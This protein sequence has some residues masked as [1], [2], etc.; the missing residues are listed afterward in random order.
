MEALRSYSV[1]EQKLVY[2]AYFVFALMWTIG[3][4]VA[5]DKITN[6]RRAFN[7]WIKA[8]SKVKFPDTGDAF[9]YRF[10]AVAKEWVHWDQF[11]VA[12]EPITERMYQNIVV[13]TVELERM[14]YVLDL[15]VN[16]G[17]PVLYVGT[18]G[19]SK[20]TIVK[21]YL[22]EVAV[23]RDDM[24]SASINHNNYTSS[25]ALQA[26]MTG[27]LDKR[28]GRTYGPPGNRKCIFFIDDLNMPALDTYDTQSAIML[29]NQIMSYSSVFDRSRLEERK[30]LTDI[31]FTACMNPKSGSFMINTRLQRHFTC[32]TTFAPTA[33]VI[34]GI[35]AKILGK[36]LESFVGQVQKLMEPIVNV[37]IDTLMAILNTSCFLPSA[38][39]FFYQ[40]N[41]KD[42]SN[43]FQ[44]LLNTNPAQFREG[45]TK[46]ARVWVHEAK[47]V[48]A[49]RLINAS[50]DAEL[51][52]ILE[53][54]C[55]KHLQGI[56]KDELFAEPLIF[57]SFCSML[58]GNDK[59]YLPIKE[60]S[61]LKDVVEAKLKE[62]NESYAAM[63]L[64]LFD[65]ALCHVCR[66]C[67]ITD[68]PCGNALLVGLV[69]VESRV[70]RAWPASSTTK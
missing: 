15:H 20:T 3:G 30:D 12:Y 46:F 32:L 31:L 33:D 54:V 6:H 40:F 21:D 4:I 59:V 23:K 34:S 61:S 16:R 52:A 14:K 10:D 7:G 70:F 18:A 66:V 47:R 36:H 38:S 11:V 25:F 37:M 64:V 56:S 9:D 17:K 28:T 65:V 55:G 51:Q 26:I 1:E 2:E 67:R 57:T 50:D 45:P 39:K 58:G 5:D 19:T 41:L 22:N 44:S 48:F 35:Y 69:A 29:L 62:Y 13:S 8:T 27:Y 49:D 63:N 60:M 24:M 43:I 68:L 53:K 42:V